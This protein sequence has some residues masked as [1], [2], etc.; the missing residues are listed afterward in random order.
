MVLFCVGRGGAAHPNRPRGVAE[1]VGV[2][3]ADGLLL[4]RCAATRAADESLAALLA[5]R[6]QVRARTMAPPSEPPE[7]F[8]PQQ[9]V[10][11]LPAWGKPEWPPR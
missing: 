5:R 4:A 9:T 10:R 3:E 7:L 11:E 8:Q 6:D 2:G 1:G